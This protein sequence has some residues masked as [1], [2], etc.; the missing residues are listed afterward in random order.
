MQLVLVKTLKCINIGKKITENKKIAL[1]LSFILDAFEIFTE[2]QSE[3]RRRIQTKQRKAR[4]EKPLGITQSIYNGR[5]ETFQNFPFDFMRRHHIN[6]ETILP[7]SMVSIYEK[8]LDIN[9]LL[10]RESIKQQRIATFSLVI[11]I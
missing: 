7:L 3:T 2:I 6:I 8:K 11:L 5:L 10:R 4:V 1:V 9:A